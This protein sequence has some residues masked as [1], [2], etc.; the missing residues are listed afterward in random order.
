MSDFHPSIHS[1][2]HLMQWFSVYNGQRWRHSSPCLLTG[3]TV[4]IVL[5]WRW[6]HKQIPDIYTCISVSIYLYMF[7]K[8]FCRW[9]DELWTGY[10]LQCSVR[11]TTD[12]ILALSIFSGLK[13]SAT[14][15]LCTCACVCTRAHVCLV[16]DHIRFQR[17]FRRTQNGFVMM[18]Q[19]VRKVKD[20]LSFPLNEIE[21]AA[22]LPGGPTHCMRPTYFSVRD[23][24]LLWC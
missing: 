16:F 13:I 23:S 6:V 11:E 12:E 2:I 3:E 21:A 18:L 8:R 14:N 9:N 1:S 5:M 19:Y 17:V 4:L 7:M 15:E 22:F 10:F 24:H 20:S